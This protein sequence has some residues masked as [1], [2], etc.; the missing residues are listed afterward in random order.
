MSIRLMPLLKCKLYRLT[1]SIEGE[2][3]LIL[4]LTRSEKT[5][6]F[7][8]DK[9][10]VRHEQPKRFPLLAIKHVGVGPAVEPILPIISDSPTALADSPLAGLAHQPTPDEETLLVD[11]DDAAA[12]LLNPMGPWLLEKDLHVP[13]CVSKIKF[14]TK[15]QQTNISVG[16]WL[17]VVLRVE[18]G[19][20]VAVDAKGRRKQFD[21][22][23]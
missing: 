12:T 5:D 20:D 4:V 2:L 10:V 19:D 13:D 21:I 14:S 6:Y 9:K 23:M 16:H 3:I 7:A 8:G 1:V 15:H 11:E 17:K 22:I 18:R